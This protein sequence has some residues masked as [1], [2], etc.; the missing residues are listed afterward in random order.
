MQQSERDVDIYVA[1]I[2]DNAEM[3]KEM[4]ALMKRVIELNPDLSADERNLLS[5]AYKNAIQ[6]PRKGIRLIDPTIEGE[7][8]AGNNQRA[9]SLREI[10]KQMSQEINEIANDVEQLVDTQLLPASSS[11][12]AR[13]FYHKMKADFFRYACEGMEDSDERQNYVQRTKDSY[14]EAINIAR[15]EISP[16]RPSYLGLLLNYSVFLYEVM[17]HKEEAIELSKKTYAESIQLVDENSENS[18]N[19]ANMI[20]QLLHENTFNWTQSV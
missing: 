1:Q 9:E 10:K 11:A 5:V 2:L 12:E 7:P 3:P 20:L 6:Q 19:E 13:V 17:D 18:Y 14:E 15:S 4:V 16:Y 8:N